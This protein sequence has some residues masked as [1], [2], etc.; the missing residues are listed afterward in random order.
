MGTTGTALGEP[1]I[2]VKVCGTGKPSLSRLRGGREQA[3]A[4]GVHQKLTCLA[5]GVFYQMWEIRTQRGQPSPQLWPLPVRAEEQLQL[6]GQVPGKYLKGRG[7][8]GEGPN[9]RGPISRRQGMTQGQGSSGQGT[10]CPI[11]S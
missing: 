1:C 9:Q 3:R 6:T 4:G 8:L 2:Q 11:L 5:H 7:V 10:L